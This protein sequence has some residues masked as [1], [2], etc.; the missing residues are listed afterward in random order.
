[1]LVRFVAVGLVGLSVLDL[2]LYVA[3]CY[4]HKVPV[5]IFH[6]V[7]LFLPFVAGVIIIARGRAVAEWISN[8]FDL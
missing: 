7:W 3:Q 6:A 2:G 4:V 1:M 5:Q 8:T